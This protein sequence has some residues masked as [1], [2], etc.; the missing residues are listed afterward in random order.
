MHAEGSGNFWANAEGAAVGESVAPRVLERRRSITFYDADSLGKFLCVRQRRFTVQ[1]KAAAK[2][3]EPEP[4]DLTFE[5][6]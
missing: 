4:L 1:P 3:S 2:L 6:K 5:L